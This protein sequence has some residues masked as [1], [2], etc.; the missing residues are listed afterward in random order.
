[1][2]HPLSPGYGVGKSRCR[3]N[4]VGTEES[5]GLLSSPCVV[6]LNRRAATLMHGLSPACFS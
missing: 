1:M 3:S 4:E 5:A 6:L 2:Y